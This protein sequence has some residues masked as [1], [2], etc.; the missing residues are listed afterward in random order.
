MNTINNIRLEKVIEKYKISKTKM[1]TALKNNNKNIK[2][3]S[4]MRLT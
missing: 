1:L 3:M 2:G 4:K